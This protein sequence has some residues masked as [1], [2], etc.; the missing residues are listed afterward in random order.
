[1]T[2]ETDAEI[3]DRDKMAEILE[4]RSDIIYKLSNLFQIPFR[5]G[6]TIDSSTLYDI[7]A[8]FCAMMM[9]KRMEIMDMLLRSISKINEVS[10]IIGQENAQ[11]I[12]APQLDLISALDEVS[13][14]SDVYIWIDQVAEDMMDFGAF[15]TIHNGVDVVQDVAMDGRTF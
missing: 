1:M 9:S 6:I 5:N 10:E 11:L 3:F 7:I 4:T 15:N 8:L 13:K 12:K 2:E 14:M